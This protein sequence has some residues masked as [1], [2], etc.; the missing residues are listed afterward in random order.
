[1]AHMPRGQVAGAFVNSD[2]FRLKKIDFAY[3]EVLGRV[4]DDA[5]R[6]GW[7]NG[8][9]AG[10]LSPDDV[11]RIFMQSDEYFN[12][13]GGTNPL[14]VAEVYQRIIKRPASQPEIDYW[15]SMVDKHGRVA[16]VDLIWFS[17]ETARARVSIMYQDYLGR[18]P[19]W[20]GLVQW[21]DFAL[22]NGDSAVRSAILGSDEYATRAITRYP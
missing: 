7:L 3:Q 6:A 15:A 22:R 8:M 10:T 5:G 11:Y 21:G 2:E 1:M 14:F 4:P 17:I 19:D 13:T 20:D 12:S 16:V 18:T 9:R